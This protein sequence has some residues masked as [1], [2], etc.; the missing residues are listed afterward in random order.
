MTAEP[1]ARAENEK[2]S[3]LGLTQVI[4]QRLKYIYKCEETLQTIVFKI[5]DI[6]VFQ[7]FKK[8]IQDQLRLTKPKQQ[9]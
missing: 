2:Q 3:R 6:S 4:P 8:K 1:G 7:P 5:N 9:E